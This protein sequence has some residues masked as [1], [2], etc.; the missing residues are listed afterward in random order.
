MNKLINLVL[1]AAL[2]RNYKFMILSVVALIVSVFVIGLVHDDYVQWAQYQ[3]SQDNT[4]IP[5]SVGWSFIIKYMV[6]VVA[7][8][9]CFYANKWVNNKKALE[10]AQ[11]GDDNSVLKKVLASAKAKTS[12]TS[13]KTQTK[14]TEAKK[15]TAKQIKPDASL[16]AFANIRAKQSLRTQADIVIDKKKAK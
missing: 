9:A 15:T 6:Y 3:L 8:S 7:I 1:T 4:S 2:W 5:L 12:S 10:K 14:N 16:D 13:S 11:A